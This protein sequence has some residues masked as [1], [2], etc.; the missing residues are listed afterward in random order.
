MEKY[1]E[2][3]KQWNVYRFNWVESTERVDSFVINSVPPLRKYST[4]LH[5]ELA[6]EIARVT[7]LSAGINQR[8]RCIEVPDGHVVTP[9][10]YFNNKE[11]CDKYPWSVNYSMMVSSMTANEDRI[12]VLDRFGVLSLRLSDFRRVHILKIVKAMKG[13][14]FGVVHGEIGSDS[15]NVGEPSTQFYSKLP[16]IDDPIWKCLTN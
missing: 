13:L 11:S 15:Y 14:G 2:W 9:S 8:E 1:E 10:I 12:D 4:M 3:M 7:G 5:F 16:R 6:L